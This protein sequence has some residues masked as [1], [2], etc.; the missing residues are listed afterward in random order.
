M[1]PQMGRNAS[2]YWMVKMFSPKQIAPKM[3]AKIGSQNLIRYISDSGI[4]FMIRYQIR[5]ATIEAK[6]M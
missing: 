3:H 4:N 6:Q 5:Y 2:R 1:P